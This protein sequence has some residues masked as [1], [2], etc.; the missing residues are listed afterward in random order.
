MCE[1]RDDL[2]A[3]IDAAIERWFVD[4]FHGL[5]PKLSVELYNH[6]HEAKLALKRELQQVCGQNAPAL[7]PTAAADAPASDAPPARTPAPEL[8]HD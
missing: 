8:T 1:T 2:A 6:V 4:H 7:P 3:K 5:G